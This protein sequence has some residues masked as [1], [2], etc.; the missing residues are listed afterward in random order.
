MQCVHLLATLGRR[1]RLGPELLEAGRHLT[2]LVQML[3]TCSRN[4]SAVVIQEQNDEYISRI[5]SETAQLLVYLDQWK[6][7]YIPN[8]LGYGDPNTFSPE[9]KGFNWFQVEREAFYTICG[10]WFLY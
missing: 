9:L 6:S 5:S 7:V 3:R 2:R 8:I 4:P 1:V 10:K